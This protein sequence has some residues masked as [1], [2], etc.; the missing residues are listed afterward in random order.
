MII[1][2]PTSFVSA[3]LASFVEAVEALTI[4][5]AAGSIRGWRSAF[6]GMGTALLSLGAITAVF[7]PVLLLLPVRIV[8]LAVGFFLLV[9]GLKWWRK[10]ILRAAGFIPHRNEARVYSRTEERLRSKEPSLH[11]IDWEGFFTSFNGVFV[12][13][14]EIVFIVLSLGAA[15]NAMVFTSS[16]AAAACVCVI[17]LGL[18]LH[19]PLTKIPE[20]WFKLAVGI[21]LTSFGLFWVSEGVVPDWRGEDWALIGLLAAV[22]LFSALAVVTVMMLLSKKTLK[23]R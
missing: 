23:K 15:G 14:V 21:L 6:A 13:G 3:F 2:A 18:I 5:L 7:G 9:L 20:N 12:E 10:A 8:K 4:V 16:G 1:S 17:G 19:R 11:R 22:S